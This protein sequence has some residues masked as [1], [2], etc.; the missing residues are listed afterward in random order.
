MEQ[1]CMRCDGMRC[2]VKYTERQRERDGSVEKKMS[3]VSQRQ[4]Q[5]Q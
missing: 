5:R 2:D 4:R 1:N 3:D